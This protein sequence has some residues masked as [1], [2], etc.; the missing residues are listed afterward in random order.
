VREELAGLAAR[1]S[2]LELAA[3]RVV[4][5]TMLSDRTEGH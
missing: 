5:S 4:P 2:H 3:T 1:V